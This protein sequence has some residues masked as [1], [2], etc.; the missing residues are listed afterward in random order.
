MIRLIHKA[1]FA[2]FFLTILTF[3]LSTVVSLIF[4]SIAAKVMVKQLIVF[5]GLPILILSAATTGITGRFLA[6]NR[7]GRIIENKL[8]RMKLIAFNGLFVLIPCAFYL[9]T[10]AMRSDFGSLYNT[11]QAAELLFGTFNIA[12]ILKNIRVG[13]ALAGKRKI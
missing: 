7:G 9:K 4:C 13:A 1:G 8:K 6:M 12:L 2:L 11:I 3:F 5:P 10:A